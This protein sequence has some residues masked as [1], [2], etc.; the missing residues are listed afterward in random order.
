[1]FSYECH[2]C[3]A[4]CDPGELENGVCFDCRKEDIQRQDARN[5]QTIRELNQMMRARYAV[6]RDGQMV[7]GGILSTNH[8]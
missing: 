7:Q 5:C 3:G 1:M 2:I 6:E 8:I 4:L